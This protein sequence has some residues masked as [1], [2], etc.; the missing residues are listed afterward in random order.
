[1]KKKRSLREEEKALWQRVTRTVLPLLPPPATAREPSPAPPKDPSK[2]ASLSAKGQDKKPAKENKL[3]ANIKSAQDKLPND[4]DWKTRRRIVRGKATIDGRIDLHG[5]TQE[6]AHQSLN[7]FIE[8][9]SA[10]GRRVVLVITGKGRGGDGAGVLKRSVP[11]WLDMRPLRGLVIE[12]GP[13]HAAHGGDGAL[14]V[15]LRVRA[16]KGRTRHDP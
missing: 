2:A 14:Y 12:Y 6:E 5:M 10:T 16:K 3:P 8:A 7:R 11:R 9:S 15:R 1:M 4:I 13:A